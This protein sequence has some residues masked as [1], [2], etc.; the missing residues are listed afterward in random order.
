MVDLTETRE[1]THVHGLHAR[2][3]TKFVEVAQ[4]FRSDIRVSR[5]DHEVDGKSVLGILTLGAEMGNS[6]TIH[7]S[8]SDA[9]EAMRALIALVERDFDGV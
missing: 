6:I 7:A 1:I 3:S 4:Q 2:A 5:D 8:G 9:E